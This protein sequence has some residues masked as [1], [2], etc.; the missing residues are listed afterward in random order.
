LNIFGIKFQDMAL[1]RR[2]D[3]PLGPQ[4]ATVTTTTAS[5]SSHI[6]EK[7]L[8]PLKR[9]KLETSE[10]SPFNGLQHRDPKVRFQT[11]TELLTHPPV[12]SLDRANECINILQ[13]QILKESNLRI[14]VLFISILIKLIVE[15]DKKW[16]SPI[17]G[18]AVKFLLQLAEGCDHKSKVVIFT[19]LQHFVK[20]SALIHKKKFS[21]K[22][23]KFAA[24]HLNDPDVSIRSSSLALLAHL[25]NNSHEEDALHIQHVVS[26]FLSDADAR[27]RV[28]ALRSLLTL[29]ERGAKLDA[30]LYPVTAQSLYDLSVSVRLE[31]IRVIAVFATAYP[32]VPIPLSKTGNNDKSDTIRLVDDA[33]KKLCALLGDISGEV[34]TLACR[35]LGQLN[36][37]SLPH[38]MQTLSKRVFESSSDKPARSKNFHLDDKKEAVI[39]GYSSGDVNVL[40]F[41]GGE[42]IRFLESLSAGAFVHGL[43]DE[44]MEVR[45]AAIDSI[46]QLSQKFDEFAKSSLEFLVDMFND[47][48]DLVRINALNSV[49]KVGPSLQLNEEQL[50]IVLSVLG[51]SSPAVRDSVRALLSST[52]QLNVTCLH[53]TITALLFHLSTYPQDLLHN[54][55]TLQRIGD[56]NPELIEL[57]VDDLLR[58]DRKFLLREPNLEDTAYIGI[59][60]TILSAAAKNSHILSLLP[61]FV[62]SHYHYLRDKF[63]EFVTFIPYFSKRR[64][65]FQYSDTSFLR[66]EDDKLEEVVTN[67]VHQLRTLENLLTRMELFDYKSTLVRCRMSLQRLGNIDEKY[68]GMSEFYVHYL[69]CLEIIFLVKQRQGKVSPELASTLIDETYVMQY[70]FTKI[71]PNIVLCLLLLRL[72]AHFTALSAIFHGDRSGLT[73]SDIQLL[74]QRLQHI[75]RYCQQNDLSLPVEIQQVATQIEEAKNISDV[76]TV[77]LASLITFGVSVPTL[78]TKVQRLRVR[79]FLAPSVNYDKPAEFLSFLP[80]IITIQTTLEHTEAPSSLLIQVKF[81]D[82]Q[83]ALYQI[84]SSGLTRKDDK[85]SDA[86]T[87]FLNTSIRITHPSTTEKCCLDINVVRC[88][89]CECTADIAIASASSNISQVS[90]TRDEPRVGLLALCSTPQHYFIHPLLSRQ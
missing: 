6:P 90:W 52:P 73:E 48:I 77:V 17:A 40:R 89:L 43:E 44:L 69:R 25:V 81:P 83:V 53:A 18:E 79:R 38:V 86:A 34:R 21:F 57:I 36:E 65:E 60:I 59:L 76:I 14:K 37:V 84:P 47:E 85:G 2:L 29:K 42:G 27:V 70:A 19:G 16:N 9:Q 87:Y 66:I 8:P 31:A 67:T 11:A 82:Q 30:S 72:Y 58:Y 56:L 13:T 68:K 88:F 64:R 12:N 24:C 26:R 33:F 39:E 62:E 35:M 61:P 71:E 63:P 3:S 45:L 28:E 32:N 51:D 80:H 78:T 75:K 5:T 15:L 20:S 41:G 49:Q 4:S 46:C 55:R 7:D 54:Y 74:L 50:H 1:K 22:L 23:L 10:M